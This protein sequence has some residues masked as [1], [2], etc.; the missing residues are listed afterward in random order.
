MKK[1]ITILFF[2]AAFISNAQSV[3]IYSSA[4]GAVCAG[5]SVTF[6][7]TPSGISSPTYQWYKNGTA[8][9][10]E[11]NVTY[12]TSSLSNNDQVY[13]TATPAYTA[14]SI[15]STG[16]I[17]NFDA[18]NYNPTSSRWTDL[19][20]SGNHMD[21]YSSTGYSTL[22]SATYSTDGGGSL[23]SAH[24][25]VNSI[26]GKTI[27]NTAISGN[28]GKTISAWVKFT[29]LL[30]G[31]TII[32]GIGD[33]SI[34]C[35]QLYP[36]Q[37]GTGWILYNNLNGDLVFGQTV[38]DLNTWY[39]VTITS[40][41]S[42]N[43]YIYINGIQ[44]GTTKNK[45]LSTTNT[46]LYLGQ[47]PGGFV[48][49][50]GKISTLSLYNTGL[51]AQTVLDNYNATKGRYTSSGV[52][53]SVITT[54]VNS[55]PSAT[56]TV[57]GDACINKTTLSTTSGVYTYTWT[58]DNVTVSGATTNI[59]MPTVA[60]D[61]KVSVSNGTC[62]STSSTTTI[63]TC[64]VTADGKMRPTS[65][66]TTLLSNEGG[67]NFGTG[68]NETG[69]IFN[70]TGISTT[71]GTIKATSAIVGGVISATNAITS[72]I[73]VIY[74]T[75]V[76]FG[77][78][79]STTIQS[80]VVAGTYTSSISGLTSSTPY[81]AKSFIVNKS[82]TIYGETASFTTAVTYVPPTITTTGLVL[83]LDAA[84]PDSYG[85]SGTTWTDVSNNNNSVTLPT[86]IATSYSSTNGGGSFTF[87]SNN[88]TNKFSSTSINNWN[89][90]TT[91]A[92]SVETWI[93]YTSNGGLQ[94][95]FQDDAINYRLGFDQLGHFYYDLG[96]HSDRNP[97]SATL[98]ANTWHHLV[99]TAGKESTNGNRVKSRFYID[100]SEVYSAD[101]GISSLPNI[102]TPYHFGD[103]PY[104]Y[105]PLNAS[106][107]ILR[108]Y[109]T[110]L[111]QS[112]ISLNFNAQKSRF[113]L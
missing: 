14:G 42:S 25:S 33:P 111:S 36:S 31:N 105:Y 4:T 72:N 12:I 9:S 68:T 99:I 106:V 96:S 77:T 6:T 18:A 3:S 35:Y 1:L 71:T 29:D 59:Y 97:S 21:F 23:I 63:Y 37:S 80:N 41:G 61:Y 49:F 113:G 65:S 92:I 67:I 27:N 38:L 46:P 54:T 55:S 82:G 52:S 95:Y 5:T 86:N 11:T 93:K 98:T 101:E 58:K 51:S 81:Y 108:V 75:D 78:Y 76:N 107:G 74:S 8:V 47:T 73:G 102:T 17:A 32:A 2:L 34:S 88:A 104:H 84:H 89:I 83:N 87:N 20:A 13:V 44:D 19:S 100:G 79:S 109:K 39:H 112:E 64:G 70:T 91:N 62:S 40:D 56:L 22:K 10:G 48:N 90:N 50:G 30:N 103:D 94:F 60:G 66:V 15:S 85:G 45:T 57:S 16:L 7:A 24:S 110:A 26:Y 43:N 53:S 28:Q 69:S